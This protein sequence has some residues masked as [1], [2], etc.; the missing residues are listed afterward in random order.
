MKILVPLLFA[1]FAMTGSSS[2]A[3]VLH[4]NLDESSGTT[5]ADSSGN[6]IDGGW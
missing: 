2:A 6:G 5:A 1:S 4:W 3:L